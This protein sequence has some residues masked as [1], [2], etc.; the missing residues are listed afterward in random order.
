M[1][2]PNIYHPKIWYWAISIESALLAEINTDVHFK[3]A[4]C[5]KYI[6]IFVS[7]PKKLTVSK[8]K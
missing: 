7:L 2:I 1:Y 5:K 4:C 6:N 3:C 8:K